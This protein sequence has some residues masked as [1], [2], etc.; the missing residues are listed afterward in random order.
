MLYI[1]REDSLEGV[2]I[3]SNQSKLITLCCS[4]WAAATQRCGRVVWSGQ[5]A[6]ENREPQLRRPAPLLWLGLT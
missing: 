1:V 2:R 4:T 5:L 6:A 3:Q